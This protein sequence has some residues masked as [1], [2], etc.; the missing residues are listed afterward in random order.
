MTVRVID[1]TEV[2]STAE[3]VPEDDDVIPLVD[4]IPSDEAAAATT[5]HG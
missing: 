1:L 2:L 5:H 4:A 3:K